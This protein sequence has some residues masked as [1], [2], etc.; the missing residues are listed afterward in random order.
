MLVDKP[1]GLTSSDVVNEIRRLFGTKKVGHAGTL[2]PLA[3]GLLVIGICKATRLFEYLKGNKTY[4]AE[5]TLGATSETL[6]SE[7]PITKNND[8]VKKDI[9]EVEKVL[10]GF[11]GKQKQIPPVYSAIKLNGQAAYKRV[12]NNEKVEMKPRPIEIFN[13]ELLSF[14]KDIVKIEV[15]VSAGTY[16]RSLARDIGEKLKTGAYMSNLN[17]VRSGDFDL[18]NATSLEDLQNEKNPQKFLLPLSAG[19]NHIPRINV[20][21]ELFEKIIHGQPIKSDEN[22]EIAQIW[23][24]DLLVSIVDKDDGVLQPTK[25]LV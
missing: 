24:D 7:G 25:V 2:D 16:I 21:D 3:T 19:L 20:S 9:K 5:I 17:R 10:K 1:K 8:Y 22:V 23:H 6:D 11:V 18:D 15:E 4:I 12:R 14:K 13:I